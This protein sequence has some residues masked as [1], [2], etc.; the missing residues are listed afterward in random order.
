MKF[1]RGQSFSTFANERLIE[2]IFP[3]MPITFFLTIKLHRGH[4]DA[5]VDPCYLYKYLLL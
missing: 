4:Y 3:I 5:S 1:N 2:G